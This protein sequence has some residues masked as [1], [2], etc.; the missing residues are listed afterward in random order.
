MCLVENYRV[1]FQELAVTF[2]FRE[3]HTVGHNLDD[4]F[5][6][7]FLIKANPITHRAAKVDVQ[8]ASNPTGDTACSN[9]AGLSVRDTSRSATAGGQADFRQLGTFSRSRFTADHSH[10]MCLD[11]LDDF[12]DPF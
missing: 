11:E 4:S 9:A 6:T 10:L 8:F 2:N 7:E 12:A 1:I 3:Q 5:V